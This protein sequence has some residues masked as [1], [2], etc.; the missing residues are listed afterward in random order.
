MEN[1]PDNPI[2]LN[3]STRRQNK[4]LER[5]IAAILL[6]VQM[7]SPFPLVG[8]DPLS[9][10]PAQAVLYSP[11]TKVPRTGELALRRAIPAN[12]SM[13]AI[14]VVIDSLIKYNDRLT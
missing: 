10:S 13:K 12:T 8:W 4:K 1:Q 5:L 2:S 3:K 9:I 6:F 7:S 14:Q 11:D